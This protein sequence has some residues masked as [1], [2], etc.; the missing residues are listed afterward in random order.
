MS[1]WK[2]QVD[3]YLALGYHIAH[4]DLIQKYKKAILDRCLRGASDIISC[5]SINV[6]NNTMS[7]LQWC[8]HWSSDAYSLYIEVGNALSIERGGKAPSHRQICNSRDESGKRYWT[9]EHQY[10]LVIAKDGLMFH[11]WSLDDLKEW[12]YDRGYA[13]IVTQAEEARLLKYT[14]DVLVASNRYSE[15]GISVITHPQFAQG[16]NI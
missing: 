11:S 9:V 7:M 6:H 4:T 16:E 15:A 14:K 10:P 8:K 13:T 5:E 12:M 2:S 1:D 3:E